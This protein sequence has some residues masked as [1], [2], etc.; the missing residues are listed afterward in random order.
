MTGST[1]PAVKARLV[2]V[3]RGL[4]PDVP[5]YWTW[6]GVEQVW[7]DMGGSHFDRVEACWLEQPT[8]AAVSYM[9]L[10]GVRKQR[11]ETYE[12]IVCFGVQDAGESSSGQ[13][14]EERALALFSLFEHE[15]A[16]DPLLPGA[17]LAAGQQLLE[18]R[19]ASWAI[20]SGPF[21]SSGNAAVVAA[22]VRVWATLA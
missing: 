11:E 22:R 2:D 7:S 12:Q 16:G 20:D 21:E 1:L 15:I 14:V 4:D 10:G 17:D 6:P 18:V 8:E 13:V 19:I 9:A 5:A 3:L